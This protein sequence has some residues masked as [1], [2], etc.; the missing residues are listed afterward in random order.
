MV[1]A[2]QIVTS[3]EAVTMKATDATTACDI[4]SSQLSMS[5]GGGHGTA[6][7]AQSDGHTLAAANQFL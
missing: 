1:A 4:N 6:G 2:G 7:L 3:S 5:R